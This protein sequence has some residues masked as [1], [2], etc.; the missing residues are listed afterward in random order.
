LITLGGVQ[1]KIGDGRLSRR[2]VEA[3]L[4]VLERVRREGEPILY[5]D[6]R[7]RQ[8]VVIKRG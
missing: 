8:Q 4:A 3:L 6:A 1:V 5:V 7:F 2:K